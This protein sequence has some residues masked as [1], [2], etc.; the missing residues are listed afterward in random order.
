LI[1]AQRLMLVLVEGFLMGQTLGLAAI[2]GIF[3][4]RFGFIRS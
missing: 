3:V 4:R 2:R 1:T